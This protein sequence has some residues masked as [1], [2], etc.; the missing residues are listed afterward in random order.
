MSTVVYF[1]D[2]LY[3]I[4]Y[5]IKIDNVTYSLQFLIADSKCSTSNLSVFFFDF[6]ITYIRSNAEIF[7]VKFIHIVRFLRTFYRR[8]S[9]IIQLFSD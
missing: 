8:M 6:L 3:M 2:L 1:C 7:A 9:H 4:I 5:H